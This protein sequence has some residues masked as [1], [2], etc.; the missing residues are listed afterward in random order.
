MSKS[1]YRL[2]TANSRTLKIRVSK[3]ELVLS[4]HLPVTSWCDET[5]DL[6]YATYHIDI[7]LL[8]HK[9]CLLSLVPSVPSYNHACV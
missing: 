6:L 2:T 9:I 5:L 7:K 1:I 4:T 8:I 3:N